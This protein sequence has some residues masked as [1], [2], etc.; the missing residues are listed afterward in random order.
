[1]FRNCAMVPSLALLSWRAV[2]NRAKQTER[3][4]HTEIAI[5]SRFAV[6]SDQNG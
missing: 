1:M 2:R 4:D 6:E 3:P 5:L